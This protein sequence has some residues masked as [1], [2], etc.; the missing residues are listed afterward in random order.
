M[1]L[2]YLRKNNELNGSIMANGLGPLLG[3]P[4]LG[5]KHHIN[6]TKANVW[7]KVNSYKLDTSLPPPPALDMIFDAEDTKNPQWIT[8][9]RKGEGTWFCKYVPDVTKNVTV[10]LWV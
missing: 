7:Q 1:F 5:V 10:T 3:P 6:F 2:I 4:P 8:A 9:T